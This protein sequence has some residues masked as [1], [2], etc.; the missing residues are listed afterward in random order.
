M[1]LQN[2]G[3][4]IPLILPAQSLFTTA[5]GTATTFQLNGSGDKIGFVFIAPRSET[6]D[7]IAVRTSTVTTGG[8][9]TVG[10]ETVDGA[11]GRPTGTLVGGSS[12]ATLTT[13]TA[14]PATYEVTGLGAALTAGT[15][16]AVTLTYSSGD[17][18]FTNSGGNNGEVF[19]YVYTFD[20]STHSKVVS[21]QIGC[22][23][24]ISTSNYVNIPGFWGPATYTT[25][26]F[27]DA[28]NPDEVGMIFN[29]PFK[30]TIGGAFL[31]LGVGS[32]NY[33]LNLYSDP[34]GSP[35]AISTIALDP[36]IRT[37]AVNAFSMVPF[38]TPVDLS[39][40]TDYAMTI[41]AGTS[42]TFSYMNVTYADAD[43]VKALVGGILGYLVGRQNDAGA[44]SA[45]ST[46]VPIIMPL[47]SKLDDGAGAASN[48]PSADRILAG[49]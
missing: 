16:Y 15:A 4:M 22:A 19:P 6:I 29:L 21:N 3:A 39:I 14:T 5:V 7:V 8:N 1:T 32:A 13:V 30:A 43:I 27:T 33:T 47:L 11:N 34:L 40:N 42:G 31:S 41:R 24:G 10:I 2:I 23:L 48:K 49:F 17:Q 45:T 18:V 35:S 25:T 9:V 38:S 26:N 37:N 36:D 46:V 12:S 44:F 20:G 28:G